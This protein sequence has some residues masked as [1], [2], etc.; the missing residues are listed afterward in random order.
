MTTLKKT[1]AFHVVCKRHNDVIRGYEVYCNNIPYIKGSL[2][3]LSRREA[4]WVADKL[5]RETGQ[6]FVNSDRNAA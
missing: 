4:R 2:Q 3:A 5:N 6:T 1:G